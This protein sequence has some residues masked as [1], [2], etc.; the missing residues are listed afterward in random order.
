MCAGSFRVRLWPLSGDV[1]LADAISCAGLDRP[2]EEPQCRKLAEH[3]STFEQT[4]V[5]SELKEVR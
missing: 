1:D 3:A 4:Q 2:E 5:I